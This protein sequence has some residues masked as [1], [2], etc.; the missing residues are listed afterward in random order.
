MIPTYISSCPHDPHLVAV[1][2][3]SGLVYI[4]N[5]QDKGKVVYKLRGHD[6]EIVSLSWCPSKNNVIRGNLNE[7]LLLASGGKDR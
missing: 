2:S 1:G 6:T 4:V 5:F 3:K 7:D